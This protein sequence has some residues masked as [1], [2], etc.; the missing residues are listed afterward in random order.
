M[1]ALIG[2]DVRHGGGGTAAELPFRV[3]LPAPARGRALARPALRAVVAGLTG[4]VALPAAYA[5]RAARR[6]SCG[7]RSGAIRARPAHA[8]SYL[9]LRHIYRHADAI[10]TYGPHVSAYVRDQGPARAGVRGAAG[11]RR[12]VLVATGRIRTAAA[13]FQV[14]FAGR[15]APE[16][17]VDVLLRAARR[18]LAGD[19]SL[20]RPR[21][22]RSCWTAPTNCATPT[23]A[24]TL[25]SY[26]RSPRAT[27][28]S[29]GGSSSTKPSTRESP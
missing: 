23:R 26:R 7:R 16:K 18:W 14:L 28:S 5:A 19:G 29:R 21:P 25:W 15:P 8:L 4:R 17:G 1:F 10:A 6:S 3:D 20:R 2:G 12:G 13:D 27:S 22:A 11:R 9:P 24:A